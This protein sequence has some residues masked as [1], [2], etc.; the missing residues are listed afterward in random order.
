MTTP[1]YSAGWWITIPQ[2]CA[3]LQ[4]TEDDW[5]EWRRGGQTPQQVTGPDG[6][7]R[8]HR[9]GVRVRTRTVVLRRNGRLCVRRAGETHKCQHE[10]DDS[11]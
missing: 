6:I 7:A 11:R 1:D 10:D 8:V 4:I 5:Q 3:E 2:I 9:T